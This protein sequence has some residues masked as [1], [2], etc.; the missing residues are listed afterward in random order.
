MKIILDLSRNCI[1][2]ASR[3]KHERMIMQYFKSAGTDKKK[4]CIGHQISALKY[5]LEQA[6]FLE[7][8][9]RCSKIDPN[10]KAVLIIPQNFKD[11]HIRF[12]ETILYPNW[13]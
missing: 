9:N 11:M 12:N 7:L 13:K 8:R 3:K 1:E 4:S 6:D 10:R 2:T 5:F